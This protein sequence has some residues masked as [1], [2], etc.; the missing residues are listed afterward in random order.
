VER[1]ACA[2][3]RKVH[4]LG[5]TAAEASFLLG[6][7]VGWARLRFAP[8]TIAN[9]PSAFDG[10][11]IVFAAS[12]FAALHDLSNGL[13]CLSNRR[14]ALGIARHV[15]EQ[16]TQQKDVGVFARTCRNRRRCRLRGG[17]DLGN[18]RFG[19]RCEQFFLGLCKLLLG[20]PALLGSLNG[21]G[22]FRCFCG[23]SCRGWRPCEKH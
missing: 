18:T 21:L 9:A 19:S 13:L 15:C 14:R 1:H 3:M 23:L 8:I 6:C 11:S 2:R 7:E 5:G 16:G 4:K 17:R 12:P 20:L 10:F 22:A